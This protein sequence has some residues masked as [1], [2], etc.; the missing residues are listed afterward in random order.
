MLTRIRIILLIFLLLACDAQART[1]WLQLAP[2]I[3]YST[4][5][6]T[7]HKRSGQLHAFK[8][9]LHQYKLALSLAK[10][11]DRSF[12]RVVNLTTNKNALIGING[13]FFT[14]QM[15]PLGLR[16]SDGKLRNRIKKTSWWGV[17]QIRR[18]YPA[19][20][21]LKQFVYR[22]D[23]DFAIQSGPRLVVRGTIPSLKPGL[24]NRSA[25]GITRDKNLIIVATQDLAM[26][27][28]ELAEIMR[29]SNDDDGLDCIDA[30]NLDGGSSTQLYA[31]IKNFYLNVSSFAPISDAVVV[32]RK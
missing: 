11:S 5:K 2:G 24:D 8:I 6:L 10:D 12:T 30:L 19:I 4:I 1:Q 9:D 14:P 29:A 32:Q 18:N 7:D 22:K 16:I 27:T 28:T 3:H 20:Y 25:L 17:F 26:T 23:I 21:S 31:N 13:G 15:Q